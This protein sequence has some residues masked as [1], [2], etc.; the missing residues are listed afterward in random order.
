MKTEFEIEFA[1][2]RKEQFRADI[3]I[4]GKRPIDKPPFVAIC[5]YKPRNQVGFIK[6]RD[7]ER[8]AVNILKALKSKRLKP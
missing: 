7:L 1:G 6:D 3:K 5:L 4:M 8:F 2:K